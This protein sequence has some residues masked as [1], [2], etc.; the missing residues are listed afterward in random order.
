MKPTI[1][2]PVSLP[3]LVPLTKLDFRCVLGLINL[4]LF[5]HDGWWAKV[6]LCLVSIICV[7]QYLDVL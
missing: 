6:G 4:A 1:P 5:N 2:S 7:L 3:L